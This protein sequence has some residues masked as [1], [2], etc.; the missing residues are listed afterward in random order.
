MVHCCWSDREEGILLSMALLATSRK[1]RNLARA[2][3]IMVGKRV[4]GLALLVL[5][6]W[7][8]H[9]R[10]RGIVSAH[11]DERGGFVL[12]IIQAGL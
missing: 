6:D 8:G 3:T 10:H 12:G 1:T 9:G 4:G 5:V 7:P 2:W 11:S